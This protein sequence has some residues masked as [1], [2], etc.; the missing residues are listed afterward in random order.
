M[1]DKDG[2]KNNINYFITFSNYFYN[3]NCFK[4]HFCIII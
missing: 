4:K 1:G 3:Y 2:G